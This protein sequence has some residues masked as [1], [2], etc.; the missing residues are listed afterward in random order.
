MKWKGNGGWGLKSDYGK[1][2]NPETVETI[3]GEVISVDKITPRKGMLYGV[4]LKV[5]VNRHNC[6]DCNL[7]INKSSCPA[8]QS[9]LDEKR[10][11][12]DCFACGRCIGN[13][14][15]KALKFAKG[16]PLAKTC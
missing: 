2:Y 4:H 5:K 11:H 13:C 14:P 15:E 10:F 3:S 9:I 8:V 16:N 6:K 7:C 12:P 1:M